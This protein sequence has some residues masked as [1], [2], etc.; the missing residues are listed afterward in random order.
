MYGNDDESSSYSIIVLTTKYLAIAELDAKYR[1]YVTYVIQIRREEERRRYF[2]LFP[3]FSRSTSIYTGKQLKNNREARIIFNPGLNFLSTALYIAYCNSELLLPYS[4][5]LLDLSVIVTRHLP[6]INRFIPFIRDYWYA[7]PIHCMDRFQFYLRIWTIKINLTGSGNISTCN[8][9]ESRLL[10]SE[11]P[12][13]ITYSIQT[14][15]QILT[16]V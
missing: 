8:Y 11:P 4:F 2:S 5:Q 12:L 15:Q 14:F 7:S 10:T 16:P 13:I 3:K 6:R 9:H 1:R